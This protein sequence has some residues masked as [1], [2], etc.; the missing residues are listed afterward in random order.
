MSPCRSKC[1][2]AGVSMCVHMHMCVCVCVC[3]CVCVRER[4]KVRSNLSVIVYD[5]LNA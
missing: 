5:H 2:T 4:A 3:L 1:C